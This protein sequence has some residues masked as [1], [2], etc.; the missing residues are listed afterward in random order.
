MFASL[1]GV[2]LAGGRS[3]R[4]GHDKASMVVDGLTLVE[5]TILALRT[6]TSNTVVVGSQ[7]A[8]MDQ[9]LGDSVAWLPDDEQFAGPVAALAQAAAAT[10][11]EWLFVLP[12]DLAEPKKAVKWLASQLHVAGTQALLARD[13]AG[14]VQWLTAI[15]QREALLSAVADVGTTDVPVRRILSNLTTVFVD[16]PTDNE[17]IWEDMDTP[18]DVQ[19][20]HGDRH[21]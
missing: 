17:S 4:M 16:P 20:H 3:T 7:V 10:T 19:R 21:D 12:C 14:H 13:S 15:V 9:Q 18:E 11:A 8:L 2:V 6:V 5:R 1:H